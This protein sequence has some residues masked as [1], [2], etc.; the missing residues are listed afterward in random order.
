MTDGLDDLLPLFL[1]EVRE[2]LERLAMLV[3]EVEGTRRQ[4]AAHDVSCTP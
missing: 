2:R 1:A 3:P 4:P